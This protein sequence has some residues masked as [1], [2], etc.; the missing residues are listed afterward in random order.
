MSGIEFNNASRIPSPNETVVRKRHT[1]TRPTSGASDFHDL[2]SSEINKG[3]GLKFSA[4]ALSRMA[5]RKIDISGENV[6]KIGQA[7]DDAARKGSQESLVLFND[8]ALIV[9][10]RNRTVITA[11]DREQMK[12]QVIT[13]IDSTVMIRE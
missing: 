12:E 10:V 11:M 13:N 8:V 6:R 4:H 2:L 1:G 9:S 7:V 3:Q 5:D